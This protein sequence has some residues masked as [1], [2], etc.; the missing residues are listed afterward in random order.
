MPPLTENAAPPPADNT[1]KDTQRNQLNALV[2]LL[3]ENSGSQSTDLVAALDAIAAAI[4]A[5][6]S[7]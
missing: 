2:G 4:N 6:P 1:T 3:V 5:K 7:A